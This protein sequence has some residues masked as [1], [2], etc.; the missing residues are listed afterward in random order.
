MACRSGSDPASS[1][2]SRTTSDRLLSMGAVRVGRRRTDV[3]HSV[4]SVA[5]ALQSKR[6]QRWPRAAI[7]VSGAER[8][9]VGSEQD[10]RHSGSSHRYWP[11]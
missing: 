6:T 5:D 1:G 3:P 4:V 7:G 8:R 9:P 2:R 11:S 10:H